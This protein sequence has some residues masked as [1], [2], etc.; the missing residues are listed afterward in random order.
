MTIPDGTRAHREEATTTN[1]QSPAARAEDEKETKVDAIIKAVTS[2]E[3]ATLTEIA[4]HAGITTR[5]A[6]R[7]I[8]RVRAEKKE[9]G[10]IRVIG[11]GRN[12]LYLLVTDD[13]VHEREN[14]TV[15]MRKKH[16]EEGCKVVIDFNF[17]VTLRALEEISRF[18]ESH[19]D[20]WR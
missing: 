11:K 6:S 2:L 16:G 12:K 17:T 10:V 19:Q 9:N 20:S 7:A 18:V 4:V 1:H 15:L 13:N 5:Q 3:K 8:A 14:P